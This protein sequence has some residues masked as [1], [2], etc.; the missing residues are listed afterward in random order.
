MNNDKTGESA[1]T[2]ASYF[3]STL[4]KMEKLKPGQQIETEIVSIS[5][6]CIFL[7]LS[8]KSE[9]VLDR[10]ELTDA[11]GKLTVKEG[12]TVKVFFR[13]AKNGEMHFTTRIAGE[14]AGA[15][16]LENAFKNGIPVDG[17]VEK[18]IKGGYEV[19]IGETRAFCPFSQMGARRTEDSAQYVG[20]RLT[21][22]IQEFKDRG[23]SILVSNRAILEE[24]RKEQLEELKKTLHE[25]MTVKGTIKSIQDFGAFVDLDG[26]Q[27]LLPVSEISRSRVED[28]HAVLAVGQEIEADLIRV[29]WKTERLTLSMKS[30]EADPWANVREKYLKDSKHTGTVVRI[31]DFGAFVSLES[32]VDG[33]IHI[34]EM[35]GE[36]KFG[37]PKVMVKAGDTV[38]VRVLDVDVSKR[39]ISL[40]PASSTDEEE[41]SQKYFDGESDTYNPFAALLKKK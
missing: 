28:I 1:N 32:G 17:L 11:D 40:K 19:K 20:K 5:N 4:S 35:R 22:K 37:N 24:E 25:G 41:V 30:R 3:E 9:G 15:S 34:S 2:F 38:V 33:L 26:V 6:D 31:A 18:E 39:R 7:Q 12:D 36:D 21:F 13:D 8:G 23:R 14:S 16:A 29:D 27:A 10:A